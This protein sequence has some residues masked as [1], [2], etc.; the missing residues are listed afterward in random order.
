MRHVAV[1]ALRAHAAAVGEVDRTLQFGVDVVRI[2]W[3]PMQNVSVLVTS[4][5]VLKPPQKMTPAMKPTMVR[6]PRL[7]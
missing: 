1:R 3:Q 4:I 2:S 7:K 5:A 6:K